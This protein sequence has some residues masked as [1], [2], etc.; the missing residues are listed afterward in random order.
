MPKV[1]IYVKHPTTN[2]WEIIDLFEDE[3]I[4]L[5]FKLK[6]LNDISKVF[7]TFSQ[8]FVVPASNNNN[9]TFN[10]FFNTSLQRV[11]ERGLDAKIYVN[12]ALF[13]T[14]QIIVKQGKY[15]H[16]KLT[17]YSIEFK[18]VIGAI[19][20]KI[21]DDKLSDVIGDVLNDGYSMDWYRDWETKS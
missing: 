9:K 16:Y 5:P 8:D 6:D 10:Y 7:S 20:D 17:S 21:G 12:D 11:R 4:N 3:S 13:R 2:K 1:D 14:G 19:K 15:E 18:T